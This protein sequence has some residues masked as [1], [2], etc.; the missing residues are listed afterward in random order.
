MDAEHNLDLASRNH[1]RLKTVRALAVN[2]VDLL[3]Y[4]TVVFSE[5][6]LTALSEVLAR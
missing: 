3:G 6:A 1:P 2:V 4:D 5:R